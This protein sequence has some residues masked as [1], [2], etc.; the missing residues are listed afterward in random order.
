[1]TREHEPQVGDSLFKANRRKSAI[2]P[3]L[4]QSDRM[5]RDAKTLG[6]TLFASRPELSLLCLGHLACRRLAVCYVK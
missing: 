6:G 2:R 5:G 3:L 4:P 1:M